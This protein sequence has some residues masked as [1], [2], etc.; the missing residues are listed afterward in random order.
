MESSFRPLRPRTED[1]DIKPLISSFSRLERDDR[2]G[3]GWDV[4][5]S[6]LKDVSPGAVPTGPK[7]CTLLFPKRVRERRAGISD[8]EARLMTAVSSNVRSSNAGSPLINPMSLMISEFRYRDLRPLI[9][10]MAE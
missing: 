1:I 9:T 7:S 10:E 3:S 5:L 2:S 8:R 4:I 6:M